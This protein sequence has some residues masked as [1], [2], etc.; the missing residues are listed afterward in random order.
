MSKWYQCRKC[1]KEF[2]HSGNRCRHVCKCG[3]SNA[4][5]QMENEIPKVK[6]L[7]YCSNKW[8]N[9]SFDKNFNLQRHVATCKKVTVE[10]NKCFLCKKTFKQMTNFHRHMEICKK[11][12]QIKCTNCDRS[13]KRQDHYN[14]HIS[15][16]NSHQ[17]NIHSRP[18]MSSLSIEIEFNTDSSPICIEPSLEEPFITESVSPDEDVVV[19]HLTVPSETESDEQYNFD[20]VP[21][22]EP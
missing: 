2:S 11:E 18:T 6:P 8:C 16:C 17:N 20:I 12:N 22:V 14:K 5:D 1:K 7:F 13:Y 15:K 10:S 21:E 4:E 3:V 9:K 19:P